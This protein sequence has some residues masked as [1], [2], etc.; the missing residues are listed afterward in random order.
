MRQLPLVI[1]PIQRLFER[2]GADIALIT[3]EVWPS[4]TIVRLAALV[5]DPAAEESAYEAAV[6]QW[7]QDGRDERTFPPDPGERRFQD[8]SLA[9]SD[10][11]GTLYR[12][13]VRSAGGSGR[14]FRGEWH[15]P[16]AVPN[17]AQRLVVEATDEISGRKGAAEL[18]LK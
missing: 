17:E 6:D 14:Y 15:F 5:D 4:E 13:D 9:L 16:N 3:V 1:S 18:S 7:V 8:V 2:E 11:V 10:D 12:S